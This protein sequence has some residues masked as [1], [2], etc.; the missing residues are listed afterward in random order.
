VVVPA[1]AKVYVNGYLTKSTG[2]RRQFVSFG[3][4]PGFAYKYDVRVE[5]V[6]DGKVVEQN[7]VAVLR[8]GA[9]EGLSFDFG[10]T[11]QMAFNP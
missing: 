5:V 8:A 6:R 1:D 11:M 9:T 4:Q 2:T 3:L 10:P 7:R